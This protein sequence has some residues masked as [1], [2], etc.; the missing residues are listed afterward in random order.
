MEIL[1]Q[2]ADYLRRFGDLAVFV[3]EC[4][5]EVTALSNVWFRGLWWD[6]SELNWGLTVRAG[7]EGEKEGDNGERDTR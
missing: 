6:V 3:T 2:F 4:L 1:R 5:L 7:Y